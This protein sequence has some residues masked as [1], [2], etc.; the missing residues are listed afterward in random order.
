VDFFLFFW[1]ALAWMVTI[2]VVPLS[3][4]MAALAFRIWR[5]TSETDIE[6]S[7]LWIRAS[8]AWG[9]LALIM[10]VFVTVD[11][12]LADY[13]QFPAGPIHLTVFIGFVALAGWVMTY[14]FSLGDYFEGISLVAIYLFLPMI[15]LFLLNGLLGLLNKSLR[16]WDPLL[17]L[18]SDFLVKPG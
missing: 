13:A 10:V 15:V 7:E 3:L 14:L 6:G 12:L 16:F 11:W 9:A 18:A 1:S 8:L 4:P 17:N 2:A 5:E